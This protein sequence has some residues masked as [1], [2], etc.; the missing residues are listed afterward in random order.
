M[1]KITIIGNVIKKPEMKNEVCK[2][3]V[4]VNE[5]YNGEEKTEFFNCV[6]FK[7]TAEI[8][9]KYLDKGSKVWI[10]G[11]QS[12]SEYEGKRYTSLIVREF[13]FISSAKKEDTKPVDSNA[14]IDDEI[15][16]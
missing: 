14:D 9:E 12:T 7:K 6:A 11:K 2:F 5:K 8:L 4:A 16:F 3:S 10:E 1:Q 13:E 15:P